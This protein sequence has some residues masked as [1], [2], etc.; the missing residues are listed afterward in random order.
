MNYFIRIFWYY[1]SLYCLQA[2]GDSCE[3]YDMVSGM[4]WKRLGIG[5]LHLPAYL[6]TIKLTVITFAAWVVHNWPFTSFHHSLGRKLEGPQMCEKQQAGP[7]SCHFFF[8]TEY[9]I[10]AVKLRLCKPY[11]DMY[12]IICVFHA[13]ESKVYEIKLRV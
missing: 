12:R 6:L 2:T 1:T 13:I 5:V 10:I 4:E 11:S 3:L 9:G 7:S 8:R